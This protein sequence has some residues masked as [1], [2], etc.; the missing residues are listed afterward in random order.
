MITTKLT[1]FTEKNINAPDSEKRG[2]LKNFTSFI[3]HSMK[4]MPSD[5]YYGHY[6][7]KA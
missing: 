5:T 3:R 1:C 2:L 7:N 6:L 4:V